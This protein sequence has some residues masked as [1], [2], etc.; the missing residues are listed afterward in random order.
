MV[1]G[2]PVALKQVLGE[3]DFKFTYLLDAESMLYPPLMEKGILKQLIKFTRIS[4][5]DI[6]VGWSATALKKQHFKFLMKFIWGKITTLADVVAA[7]II[8]SRPAP[9]LSQ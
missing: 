8:V 7:Q 4:K 5:F 9:G 1:H 6:P 2:R 3:S